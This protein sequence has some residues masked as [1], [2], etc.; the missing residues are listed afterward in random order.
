FERL[1][2][3]SDRA[4]RAQAQLVSRQA[5]RLH[6]RAVRLA[7]ATPHATLSRGRDRLDALAT[8]LA[9]AISQRITRHQDALR[10]LERVRQTVGY[11]ATLQRGYAV[12]KTAD[13]ALRTTR[14][15]SQAEEVLDIQFVDGSLTVVPQDDA[16][17][18]DRPKPKP[19]RAPRPSSKPEQG[20]LF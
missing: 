20:S 11:E 12:V 8:R 6:H 2:V 15:A 16:P 9:P 7:A 10:A 1:S 13:G 14:A 5:E 17:P 4:S 18:K 3:I 19:K